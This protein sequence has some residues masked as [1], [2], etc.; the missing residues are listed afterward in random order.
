MN[1]KIFMVLVFIRFCEMLENVVGFIGIKKFFSVIV[2]F[3]DVYRGKLD[4]EMFVYVVQFFDFIFEWCIVFG[5]S[6]QMI[7]VVYDGKMKCVVVVSKYLMYEFGVVDLV[8][9][10]LDELFVIDLKKF[11]VVELTEFE[12]E[13]EMEKED[14][15]ELFLFNVVVDDFF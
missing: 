11:V 14:E 15:C 5:N 4:F 2:V 13:L 10:R 8:V 6:N 1:N 12:L 9:R 3:E 7:E